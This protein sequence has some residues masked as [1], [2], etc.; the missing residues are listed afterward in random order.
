VIDF[1]GEATEAAVLG[2][3]LEGASDAARA[4]LRLATARVG[5]AVATSAVDDPTR[6]W[7]K[8][9]GL[10]VEQPITEALVAEI[11]TFYAAHGNTR[12]TFQVARPLL[13]PDWDEICARHRLTPGPTWYKLT[14]DSRPADPG[15]SDLEVTPIDPADA[16]EA[17][18]VLAQGFGWNEQDMIGI[19]GQALRTGRLTGFAARAAGRMIATGA[20]ATA[21]P[22]G[23]MYGAATLPDHRGRGAQTALLAARIN[24]A[25]ARG[26]TT[27]YAE[28]WIPEPGS[29]N[30]S[31]DN[32]HRAGFTTLYDR[33]SWRWQAA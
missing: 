7:S 26:C 25:A 20:L 15:P 8:V 19:Y 3:L 23:E 33:P 5:G 9:L 27:L 13:P 32:L 16:D 30:P 6:F 4:R 24:A 11:L 2:S 22:A 1:G 29:R 12:T 10:G 31:L 14:R 21:G 18:V 17:A 28:T